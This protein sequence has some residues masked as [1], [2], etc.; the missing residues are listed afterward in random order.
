MS[1]ASIGDFE[2]AEAILSDNDGTVAR[3]SRRAALA[4]T[5]ILSQLDRKKQAAY[6]S[7]SYNYG[8]RSYRYDYQYD[9]AYHDDD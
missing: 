4:R 5:E 8:Y 6:G 7:Y 2:G 9:S 3:F 1:L